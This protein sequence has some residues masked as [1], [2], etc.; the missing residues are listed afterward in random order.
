MSLNYIMAPASADPNPAYSYAAE[1]GGCGS[2]SPLSGS[3]V[4]MLTGYISFQANGAFHLAFYWSNYLLCFET[5]NEAAKKLDSM[6]SILGRQ[7]VS[8]ILSKLILTDQ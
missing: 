2:I 5:G 8:L 4:Y 3:V 1:I 7:N 6:S